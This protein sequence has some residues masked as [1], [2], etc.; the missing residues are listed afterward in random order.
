MAR[1]KRSKAKIEAL[2]ANR[3]LHPH[4]EKVKDDLFLREEFFDPNDL[5]QVKYEMLRRVR[6]EGHAVQSTTRA[7]GF[8]RPTYYEAQ[9]AYQRS[10]LL[11]LL[12]MKPGPR[13]A[14]KL[15]EAVMDWVSEELSAEPPP[16]APELVE[17]IERRFGLVVHPRSIQRA[18]ARRKK[19]S[20]R[21][22]TARVRP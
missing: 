15:S 18:V 19:K 13:R 4:P 16:S 3:S 21:K 6:I 14:H 9:V 12:R 1:R 20:K 11:G 22:T 5:L 17:R 7:F 2:R 8:S 10:G